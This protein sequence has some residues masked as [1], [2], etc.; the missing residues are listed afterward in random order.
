MAA[1]VGLLATNRPARYRLFLIAILGLNGQTKMYLTPAA[2]KG[3]HL[4]AAMFMVCPG[5][6][7]ECCL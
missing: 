7:W 4:D 3:I 6:V 2:I 1:Y 5:C